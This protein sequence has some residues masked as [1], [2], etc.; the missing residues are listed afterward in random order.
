MP[1]LLLLLVLVVVCCVLPAQSA[2]DHS[3]AR[4]SVTDLRLYA[5]YWSGDKDAD[6]YQT[7]KGFPAEDDERPYPTFD[8]VPTVHDATGHLEF[9]LVVTLA[10]E[11]GPQP[12]GESEASYGAARRLARWQKPAHIWQ[13]AEVVM[14][15]GETHQLRAATVDLEKEYSRYWKRNQWPYRMR[16][17]VTIKPARGERNAGTAHLRKEFAID[18]LD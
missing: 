4:V 12:K 6:A 11:V 15:D 8:I 10:Y 7:V 2:S 1:R 14:N 9:T 5:W 18:M 13:V 3:T 17:D 16:I